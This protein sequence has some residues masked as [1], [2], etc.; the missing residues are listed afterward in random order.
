[1]SDRD[2][3]VRVA[4]GRG[5]QSV[6]QIDMHSH[7]LG[8]VLRYIRDHPGCARTDIAAAT[9]LTKPG[10]TKLVGRLVDGGLVS[11]AGPQPSG[12]RGR[13]ANA[14][15]LAGDHVIGIGLELRIDHVRATV[16]DLSGRVRGDASL[17]LEPKPEPRSAVRKI[18]RVV[19]RSMKLAGVTSSS[20]VGMAIG[21]TMDAEGRIAVDSAWLGWSDV[22]IH[23]MVTEELGARCGGLTIESAAALS[24]LAT[25]RALPHEGAASLMHLEVGG[26]AGIGLVRD[27]RLSMPLSKGLIGHIPFRGRERCGC[28]NVGCLDT[29]IGFRALLRLLDDRV[30]NLNEVDQYAYALGVQQRAESGDRRARRALR[31]LGEDVGRAMALLIAL[32]RPDEATYGGYLLGLGPRF[33]RAAQRGIAAH[34]YPP[35][36]VALTLAATPL[37]MEGAVT[38]AAALALDPVF[39]D[40]TMA[41]AASSR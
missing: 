39:A 13:P 15:S 32:T 22:P 41:F 38:G 19:R 6:S 25:R 20:G 5:R 2:G 7:N 10:V 4:G 28:G 27:G 33:E 8:L 23:A 24:A 11:A 21:S 29:V 31:V 17:L 37:G 30:T 16:V 12:H 3:S 40:P 26:G 34:S 36:A 1:M 35:Q 18:G 14:L 9:G